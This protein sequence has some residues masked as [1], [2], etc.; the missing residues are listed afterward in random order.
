MIPSG[1]PGTSGVISYPSP[2]EGSVAVSYSLALVG[3]ART[4]SSDTIVFGGIDQNGNYLNEV[5][6]LR[7]YQYGIDESNETWPAPG[8]G[9]LETGVDASGAG[10][11]VQFLTSCV[12]ALSTPQ[13]TT[14]TSTA[15][16]S[17]TMK[18]PQPTNPGSPQTT[19]SLPDTSVYHKV[20]SPLSVALVFP[21]FIFQRALPAAYLSF[22]SDLSGWFWLSALIFLAAYALGIAGFA[23]AFLTNST[24]NPSISRRALSSSFIQTGHAKAGIA[25][26]VALYGCLPLLLLVT[27]LVRLRSSRAIEGEGKASNGTSVAG[28]AIS[29]KHDISNEANP[30]DATLTENS[31]NRVSQAVARQRTYSWCSVNIWPMGRSR[32]KGGRPSYESGRESNEGTTKGFE[33]LNRNTRTRRTSSNGLLPSAVDHRSSSSRLPRS[34]SDLSWLDRRRSVNAVVSLIDS[35]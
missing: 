17:S 31:L 28:L 20:L 15:S 3:E 24:S 32:D 8:N 21:A 7:A 26:F 10:V 27:F 12:T 14:T 5:W 11:T 4:T 6:L 1:D 22:S 25:F 2:R 9:P 34:L 29:E 23:T 18:S 13:N 16:G 30:H 35:T 19:L 33:V